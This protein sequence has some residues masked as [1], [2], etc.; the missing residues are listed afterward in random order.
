MTSLSWPPQPW[1]RYI[2][3]SLQFEEA[4]KILKAGALERLEVP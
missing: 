1:A 2:K 3:V 4:G